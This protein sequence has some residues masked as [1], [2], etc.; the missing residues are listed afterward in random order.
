MKQVAIELDGSTIEA[1][2]MRVDDSMPRLEDVAR[3]V[4]AQASER[5]REDVGFRRPCECKNLERAADNPDLPIVFDTETNEYHIVK[6]TERG[7]AQLIVRY[8]FSCGGKAPISKRGELFAWVSQEE[9]ARLMTLCNDI[10]TFDDATR[11]FG[12]PEHDFPIG[13]TAE[14]MNDAGRSEWTAHRAIVYTNLSDAADVRFTQVL[15][16]QISVRFFGK[17]LGEKATGG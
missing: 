8:C 13:E 10:R 16:D 14:T 2:A 3:H 12:Q 7:A 1:L 4:L 11:A 9:K 17:H 5:W 6:E 15:G